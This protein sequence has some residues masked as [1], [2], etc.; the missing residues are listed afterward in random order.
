MDELWIILFVVVI[1]GFLFFL[2][3]KHNNQTKIYNRI[4]GRK[5]R[6]YNNTYKRYIVFKAT[7]AQNLRLELSSYSKF[8]SKGDAEYIL[9]Y[10]SLNDSEILEFPKEFPTSDYYNLVSR[11]TGLKRVY[12]YMQEQSDSN[13][14]LILLNDESN[15][16]GDTLIGLTGNENIFFI[17][18]Y[19]PVPELTRNVEIGFEKFDEFMNYFNIE[20]VLLA[21]H[22]KII[23]VEL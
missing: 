4:P 19:D 21:P 5:F 10:Y 3:N 18:L 11:T 1:M 16:A 23:R 12:G 20:N 9:K 8:V 22:S 13:N 15:K 14:D 6:I 2:Y 7:D 17:N